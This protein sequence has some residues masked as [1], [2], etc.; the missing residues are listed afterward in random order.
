MPK[1]KA[2]GGRDKG[3]AQGIAEDIQSAKSLVTRNALKN[4]LTIQQVAN[5]CELPLEEVIS[6]SEVLTN[7]NQP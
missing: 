4:G 2:E 7:N 6:L 5:I 1:S 3:M